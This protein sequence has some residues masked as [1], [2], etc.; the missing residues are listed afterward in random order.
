MNNAVQ[1][2]L[3]YTSIKIVNMEM[4]TS[5]CIILLFIKINKCILRNNNS[6]K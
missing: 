5:V 1:P 2:K 3:K 4:F 6:E